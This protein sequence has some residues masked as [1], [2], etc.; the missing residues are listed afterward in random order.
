MLAIF[1]TSINVKVPALLIEL[2]RGGFMHC[3]NCI[4]HLRSQ[5]ERIMTPRIVPQP[6]LSA[7][8]LALDYRTV[9]SIWRRI[10]L[11]CFTHY[12]RSKK[13]KPYLD[14]TSLLSFLFLSRT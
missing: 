1:V 4:K 3:F 8:F 13:R 14:T 11:I 5:M 7:V 6:L 9:P 2:I 12:L 10:P